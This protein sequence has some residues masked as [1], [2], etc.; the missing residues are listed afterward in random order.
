MSLTRSFSGVKETKNTL[1]LS[2]GNWSWVY[3]EFHLVSER[4][5]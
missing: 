2:L 4:A 1:I 5:S 3:H